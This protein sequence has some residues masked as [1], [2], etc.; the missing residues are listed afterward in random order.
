[1]FCPFHSVD[2]T[3]GNAENES[4]KSS[5]LASLR[6]RRAKVNRSKSSHDVLAGIDFSKD[7]DEDGPESPYG[8]GSTSSSNY[9]RRKS[10]VGAPDSEYKV[11]STDEST[12][13]SS[14]A[15][16]LKNKYGKDRQQP[17]ASQRSP[18]E[19]LPKFNFSTNSYMN[20]KRL[21]F[22]F[23]SRGSDPGHFTWPRG[24]ASGPDGQIVVA[25]SSNHRIQVFQPDGT[26]IKEFGQYGNVDGEF[27]CLAGIAVNRIGQ[28]IVSD[29]YNHRIQVFDPSGR[30][31]RS[32]GSQG[33]TDG[34]F[35]YPWGLATDSLGFIYV[36]DKEN[37]RIQVFQSDGTFV[38]KFGSMGS[39]IGELEHPHYI[40]VTSTNKVIVTDTNNHR[41]SIWD[42][43][44]RVLST[45]GSEGSEDGQFKLPR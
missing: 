45:I 3:N 44:G 43:N 37:H 40:A 28:F 19:E 26:F 27:D 5:R 2:H 16:Y 17:A 30:F 7:D 42:V 12:S 36:C 38:G 18:V 1:V 10:T 34:K 21:L 4:S 41:I 6:D 32:F 22:K 31:L 35:N 11:P 39:K 20:K 15:R 8:T 29:R 9:T 13:L 33:S 24:I 25:D 14:W 23:G